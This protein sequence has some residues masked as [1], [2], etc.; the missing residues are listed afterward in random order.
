[1]NVPPTPVCA[2]CSKPLVPGTFTSVA[3]RP[4]HFRCLARETQLESIEQEDRAQRARER[5][6]ELTNRAWDLVEQR[7]S[8]RRATCSACARPLA[9][10]GGLLFQGPQLVHALCWQRARRLPDTA[11]VHH[12]ENAGAAT[13]DAGRLAGVQIL[14]VEDHPDSRDALRLLLELLGATVHTAGNGRDALAI[15]ER[16]PL[17]VLLCDLRLPDM[18]GFTVLARVRVLPAGRS[19]RVVAVTGFGRGEDVQR[20]RV[21]GFDGHLVK[22]FDEEGLMAV[23]GRDLGRV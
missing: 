9:E 10:G 13:R 4:L 7:R 17:H 1:M 19:L 12:S 8:A 3:G 6:L 15:A 16:E 18:D 2:R 22:P 23:V 20:I 21:A 14:V 5:A 11:D